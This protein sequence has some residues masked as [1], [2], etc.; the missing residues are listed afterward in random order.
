MKMR[1]FAFACCPLFFIVA[2]ATKPPIPATKALLKQYSDPTNGVSFKYPA[3][4]KMSRD[5]SFYLQPA[6]FY[7]QQSAQAVVSFSPSGTLRE[8]NFDG[9]E[10][11]YVALPEPNQASCL[12]HVTKEIDPEERKLET[13]TINGTRF[14]H[15]KAGD[16]GLCHQA[17]SN[18]YE[19]YHHGSCLLFE[20]AF[21]TVCPDPDEGEA[22]LT[23]AQ[24]KA[25]SQPLDAIIH[26][27][28]IPIE[29]E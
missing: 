19:T 4:W 10:F 24:S 8:T 7:P 20:A 13:V 17:N 14:F 27:V 1:R 15:I 18:I 11:A 21:Y 6:I 5:P 23:A 22:Q 2:P 28:Q 25:L 9:L 3:D 16:G 12:E 26:T 29:K